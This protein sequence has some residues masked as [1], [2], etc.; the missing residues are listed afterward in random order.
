[1]TDTL[2]PDW[3]FKSAME[4]TGW[5]PMPIA[6]AEKHFPEAYYVLIAFAR[7]IAAHEPEPVDPLLIEA[8]ELCIERY[9]LREDV[10]DACRA[11]TFCEEETDTLLAGIKRGM[12][13]MGK[14]DELEKSDE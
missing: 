11:G 14:N 1:M 5:K 9:G 10:A 8:R 3:A 12:E 4:R 13:L 2:P 7:H 6:C